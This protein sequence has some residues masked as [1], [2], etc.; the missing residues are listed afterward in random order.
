MLVI[1]RTTFKQLNKMFQNYLQHISDGICITSL[2]TERCIELAEEGSKEATKI[3]PKVRER[4]HRERMV[5]ID[6]PRVGR[7]K[8]GRHELYLSG[9]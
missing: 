6:L 7:E 8:N 5:A 4:S 3:V 2:V 1:V 9:I